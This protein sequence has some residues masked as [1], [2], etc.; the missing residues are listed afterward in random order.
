MKMDVVFP[1]DVTKG[2]KIDQKKHGA[3]NRTLWCTRCDR[4]GMRDEG[5]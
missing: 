4:D 3:K 1:K 2:Q 5:L